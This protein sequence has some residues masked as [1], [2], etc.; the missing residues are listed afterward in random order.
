MSERVVHDCDLCPKKDVEV[1]HFSVTVGTYV[2]CAGDTDTRDAEFDACHACQALILNKVFNQIATCSLS[3]LES[4]TT[5]LGKK[6]RLNPPAYPTSSIRD[7]DFQSQV[8]PE[9][10]ALPGDATLLMGH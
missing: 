8:P 4:L 2:D 10:S 1:A 9:G 5:L 3:V 7:F 6:P